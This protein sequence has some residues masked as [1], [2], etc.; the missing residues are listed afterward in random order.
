MPQAEKGLER[1]ELEETSL[2]SSGLGLLQG[3]G[4]K[5][6]QGSRPGATEPSA[7][8]HLQRAHWQ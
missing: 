6:G 5:P 1:G 8:G 7:H 2:D 4:D 3:G